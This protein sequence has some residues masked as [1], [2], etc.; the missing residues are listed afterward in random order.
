MKRH[1]C[2]CL[3]V[4]YELM[5]LFRMGDDYVLWDDVVNRTPVTDLEELFKHSP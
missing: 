5:R 3:A 4:L 2:C 1:T